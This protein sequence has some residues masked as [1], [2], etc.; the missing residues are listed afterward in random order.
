LINKEQQLIEKLQ[1]TEARMQKME[2]KMLVDR[3]NHH[4][5]IN[6]TMKCLEDWEENLLHREQAYERHTSTVHSQ[7]ERYTRKYSELQTQTEKAITAWQEVA[8]TTLKKKIEEQLRQQTEKIED[9]ATNH[10]KQLMSLLDGY[11]EEHA[12]G[13]Q[14]KLLARLHKETTQ[15]YKE[16]QTEHRQQEAIPMDDEDGPISTGD[17]D[18]PS[19]NPADVA[20]LHLRASR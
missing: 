2:R 13:I 12:R 18:S 15:Q 3:Q 17:N 16:V 7:L 11:D 9:F 5:Y 19:S 6:K 8:Q 10:E 1:A 20:Y 14:A 4:H